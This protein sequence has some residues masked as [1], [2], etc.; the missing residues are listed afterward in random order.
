MFQ[1][2][3][4][5]VSAPLVERLNYTQVIGHNFVWKMMGGLIMCLL[6]SNQ[7]YWILMAFL[8]LDRFVY[9]EYLLSSANLIYTKCLNM[10]G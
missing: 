4:V 10:Q 6:F 7:S 5:L 9:N 2:F 8:L 3:V 1:L